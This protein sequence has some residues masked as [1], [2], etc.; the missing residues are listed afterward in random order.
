MAA[1]PI[2][3]FSILKFMFRFFKFD[4][5]LLM[6]LAAYPNSL[7]KIR[8]PFLILYLAIHNGAIDVK[9]SDARF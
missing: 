7:S 9:G 4:P 1:Q 5:L 2:R 3:V 6:I 8:L